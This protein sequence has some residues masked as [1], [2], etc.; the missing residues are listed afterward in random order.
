MSPIDL[1]SYRHSL[2]LE[3]KAAL[4]TGGAQG[5]GRAITLAL[6]A[7]GARVAVVDNNHA[8]AEDLAAQVNGTIALPTELGSQAAAQAVVKKAGEH[9]GRLNVVIH[10]AAYFP[11]TALAAIT[12]EILGTTLDVNLAT[13]F[14]LV[15]AAI[16]WFQKQGKGRKLITSSVTGPRVAYPGLA[17]Y[18]ASKAGVN[19]FIRAAALELAP[20]GSTS[21]HAPSAGCCADPKSAQRWASH[22]PAREYW[23]PS[24]YHNKGISARG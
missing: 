11:L 7:Q 3:G 9:F 14:W 12:P 20:Q 18:A 15:Q 2:S 8:S 22:S 4:I 1:T 6:A 16:P 17:H 24:G 21:E 23:P 10:N 19:G 13:A 5:I